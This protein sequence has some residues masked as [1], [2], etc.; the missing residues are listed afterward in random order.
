MLLPDELV[1]ASVAKDGQKL[2][3]HA[4]GSQQLQIELARLEERLAA[5]GRVEAELRDALAD[6]RAR[7]DRAEARLA[8]P[9][10]RRWV[11]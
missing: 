11:G 9:W 7:L 3:L 8:M 10:W 5:A 2:A 6:S 1:A 4:N